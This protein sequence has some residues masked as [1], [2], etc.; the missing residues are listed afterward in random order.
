MKRLLLGAL[1]VLVVAGGA[2]A[3][4]VVYRE[5][6]SRNVRGSSTVEFVATEPTAPVVREEGVLWPMFGY[7]EQRDRY[8]P[9][10][11]VRPPFRAIWRYRAQSL[12]EFPPAIAYGRLYVVSNAG[13]AIAVNTRTGRKA[14]K[15][16]VGRCSAASPAVH[17]HVVFAS[18]LNRPPCNAKK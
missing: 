14:W 16:R 10:L 11:D 9:G 12:L 7:T 13:V 2:L 8:A 15:H 17:G 3:A 6:Q 4:F 1:A 18:F 5:R